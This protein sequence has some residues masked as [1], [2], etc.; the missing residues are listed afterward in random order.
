MVPHRFVFLDRLPRTLTGKVDRL[1]LPARNADRPEL[2]ADFVAPRTPL[3]TALAAI[4][5]EVLAIDVVGVN[6]RF[7]DLGGDSLR[8]GQ[9]LARVIDGFGVELDL[10]TLLQTPTIADMAMAITQ[11]Q[12][13]QLDAAELEEI[14]N[15]LEN[16][17]SA[18]V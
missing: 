14:L 3:E 13:E 2:D 7:L 11:R 5:S 4:W 10:R 1:A 16:T 17:H 12:A 15:S 18:K 6:D 8:A 9:I